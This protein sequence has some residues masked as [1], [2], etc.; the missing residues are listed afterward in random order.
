M[1]LISH[2]LNP[3][4]MVLI[5]LGLGIQVVRRWKLDWAIF[6]LGA[7]TF[8]ISQVLHIPFNQFLLNP[9][10][11]RLGWL[12]AEGWPWAIVAVLVG[13]SAGLFEEGTRYLVLRRSMKQVDGWRQ[14][15]LYGLGHGGTEAILLGGF[16]FYALFQALALRGGALEGVVPAGQIEAARLQLEAYWGMAWYEPLWATLE[17]LSAMAFHIM[18]SLF[19]LRAARTRQVVWLGGAI[20][21]HTLFN[22]VALVSLRAWGVTATELMLAGIGLVCLWVVFKMRGLPVFEPTRQVQAKPAPRSSS[23]HVD[24][25]AVETERLDD[26]RY[27]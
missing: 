16:A 18:A 25:K 20:L 7:L 2:V 6:G 24:A 1:L 13:L 8:V 22:T 14:G 10:L 17:R 3:I 15:V 21:A 4:L 9:Q 23:R 19:V 11:E 26:S 5:P 27:L 12:G